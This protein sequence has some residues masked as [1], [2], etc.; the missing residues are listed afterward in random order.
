MPAS[1]NFLQWNPIKANQQNDGTYLTDATRTGGISTG[2]IFSSALAD[3]AFYQWST[4]VAA[5]CIMMQNKGFTTSD[6]DIEALAAVLAN[7]ITTAD[8]GYLNNIITVA[9]SP[10]PVFDASQGNQF[11]MLLSGNVTG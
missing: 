6:A 11:F 3:K 5:F 7:V 4:F 9:Y 10:N 1:T 2:S 8:L